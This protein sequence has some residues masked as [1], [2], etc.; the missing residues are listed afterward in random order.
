MQWPQV[1]LLRWPTAQSAQLELERALEGLDL[2]IPE[3]SLS[4]QSHSSAVL[5]WLPVLPSGD[6]HSCRDGDV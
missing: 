2:I 3:S 6:G 4:A 1:S 5:C